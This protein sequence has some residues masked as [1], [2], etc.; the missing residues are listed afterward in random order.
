MVTAI[1]Y[2]LG[3]AMCKHIINYRN[4]RLCKRFDY[5]SMTSS[6]ISNEVV[7]AQDFHHVP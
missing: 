7:Y 5:E 4:P 6:R 2:N 1:I 3:F